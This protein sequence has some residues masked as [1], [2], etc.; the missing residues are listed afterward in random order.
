[1]VYV[2]KAYEV[3]PNNPDVLGWK[4]RMLSIQKDYDQ[5]NKFIKQLLSIKEAWG[6]LKLYALVISDFVNGK[7]G[8]VL[9]AINNLMEKNRNS[10]KRYLYA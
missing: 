5:M 6:L 4:I 10:E 9:S 7:Y 1:M 8:Y 3:D 2:E